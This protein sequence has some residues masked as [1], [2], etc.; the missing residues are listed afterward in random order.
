[1]LKRAKRIALILCSFSSKLKPEL[2]TGCS[3]NVSALHTAKRAFCF[4]DIQCFLK[5]SRQV[6]KISLI[7]LFKHCV[8][9]DDELNMKP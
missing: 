9:V 3:Q 2:Q 4:N 8:K 6:N 5:F 7:L 1:M